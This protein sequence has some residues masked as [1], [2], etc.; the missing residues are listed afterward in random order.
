MACLVSSPAALMLARMLACRLIG[1][2]LPLPG[3]RGLSAPLLLARIVGRPASIQD[4]VL[5]MTLLRML[6]PGATRGEPAADCA[7]AAAAAACA[8][9]AFGLLLLL[10][11]V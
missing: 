6:L 4:S 3:R 7:A 1:L 5:P 10:L 2:E 9:A 11:L 8:A